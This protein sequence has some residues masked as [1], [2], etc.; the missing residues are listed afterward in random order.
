MKRSM[1]LSMLGVQNKCNFNILI[2][3]KWGA[4]NRAPPLLES[5]V[6]V[7]LE[8]HVTSGPEFL[9]GSAGSWFCNFFAAKLP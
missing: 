2:L 1:A 4:S 9:S 3:T 5:L 7:L 8:E 6:L